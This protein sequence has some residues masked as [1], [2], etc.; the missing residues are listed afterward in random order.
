MTA[1]GGGRSWWQQ[2]ASKA[3]MEIDTIGDGWQWQA[4]AFSGGDG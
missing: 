1:G 4:S 2:H 3:K